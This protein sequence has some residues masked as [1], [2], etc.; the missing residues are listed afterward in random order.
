LENCDFGWNHTDLVL[1]KYYII[2][3][4]FECYDLSD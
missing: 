4:Y 1:K 2:R 3:L